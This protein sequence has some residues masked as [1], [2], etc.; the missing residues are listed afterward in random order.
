[1]QVKCTS[2]VACSG[3]PVTAT[4]TDECPG[5]TDQAFHFDLS[6]AAFGAMAKPGLADQ[7]RNVGLLQIMHTRFILI[8][9]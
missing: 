4:I 9:N 6:G 3:R 1:M 2:N 8:F 7:L 5:C